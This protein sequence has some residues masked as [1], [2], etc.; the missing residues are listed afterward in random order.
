MILVAFMRG[1]ET[2]SVRRAFS[3]FRVVFWNVEGSWDIGKCLFSEDKIKM[4]VKWEKRCEYWR[5]PRRRGSKG[6][7]TGG[8]LE[9]QR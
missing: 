6:T 7:K 4:A 3:S 5:L 2:E 8:K 9:R 1:A